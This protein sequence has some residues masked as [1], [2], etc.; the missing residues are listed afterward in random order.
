MGEP[1][2]TTTIS[3]ALYQSSLY[4]KVARQKPLLSKRYMTAHLEFAKRHLKDFQTM[5]NKILS[6][7]K[8]PRFN[9]LA[10]GEGSP[11]NKDKDNNPTLLVVKLPKQNAL[12]I[13]V[14]C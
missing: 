10:W 1:S 7:D 3:A 11:S 14:T 8:K 12:T 9:D 2:R 5:T 6:S 4:G 13:Y